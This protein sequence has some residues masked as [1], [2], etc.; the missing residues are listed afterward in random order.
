MSESS[1]PVLAAAEPGGDTTVRAPK[2]GLWSDPPREGEVVTPGSSAG[3][4]RQLNRRLTLVMPEG[5]SGRVVFEQAASGT[6]PVAYGDLLFRVV[7]VKSLAG[8]A[9]ASA[10]GSAPGAFGS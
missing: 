5:V 6:R 8:E 2:V 7:A 4:L 9:P 10:A 1:L 3:T